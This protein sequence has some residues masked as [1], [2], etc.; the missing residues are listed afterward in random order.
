MLGRM[1]AWKV[2]RMGSGFQAKNQKQ[3]TENYSQLFPQ[4][5]DA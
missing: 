5:Q 4:L 1:E 2:A 3:K